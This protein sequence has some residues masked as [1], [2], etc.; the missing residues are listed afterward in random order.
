MMYHRWLVPCSTVLLFLACEAP[1]REPGGQAHQGALVRG[2]DCN[3]KPPG[4]SEIGGDPLGARLAREWSIRCDGVTPDRETVPALDA[5]QSVARIE[6]EAALP[7]VTLTVDENLG[8]LAHLAA[9]GWRGASADSFETG[10]EFWTTFSDSISGLLGATDLD[11]W[12]AEFVLGGGA[13]Q[14]D[15]L[16][17]KR[18]FDGIPVMGNYVHIT[19]L[20]AEKGVPATVSAVDTRFTPDVPSKRVPAVVTRPAAEAAQ[21]IALYGQHLG[22]PE[23]V[24]WTKDQESRLTWR[25]VFQIQHDDPDVPSELDPRIQF[26]AFLD[27]VT[28]E[29]VAIEQLTAFTTYNGQAKARATNPH[30]PFPDATA[31]AVGKRYKALPNAAIADFYTTR[32]LTVDNARTCKAPGTCTSPCGW[33]NCTDGKVECC[34]ADSCASPNGATRQTTAPNPGVEDTNITY[35]FGV[36]RTAYDGSFSREDNDSSAYVDNDRACGHDATCGATSVAA[37][38]TDSCMNFQ[39]SKFEYPLSLTSPTITWVSTDGTGKKWP[40]RRMEVFSLL[41]IASKHL[42]DD[43]GLASYPGLGFTYYPSSARGNGCVAGW[44]MFSASGDANT[45]TAAINVQAQAGHENPDNCTWW[46]ETDFRFTVF[47]E[48]SHSIH[49]KMIDTLGGGRPSGCYN[50]WIGEGWANFAAGS[51]SAGEDFGNNKRRIGAN[52]KFPKDDEDPNI[53]PE[54]GESELMTAFTSIFLDYYLYYGYAATQTIGYGLPTYIGQNPMVGNCTIAGDYT[55]CP[56]GSLYRKLISVAGSRW[57]TGSKQ[58][59]EVAKAFHNH[60]MDAYINANE[61]NFANCDG[62]WWTDNQTYQAYPYPDEVTDHNEHGL[63]MPV[64]KAPYRTTNDVVFPEINRGPDEYEARDLWF[65][66]AD[67]QDK[68]SLLVRAGESFKV[69]TTGLVNG[70]DT[71]LEILDFA[72]NRVGYNDDC[73]PPDRSSCVSFTNS[74]GSPQFYRIVTRAY[75]SGTVG[76]SKTY[77]IR[78]TKLADDYSNTQYAP[79]PVSPDLEFRYGRL[80]TSGDQDHFY[81]YIPNDGAGSR[82]LF[83][84]FC[85]D[86][87]G[88]RLQIWTGTTM[89]TET[90]RIADCENNWVT[91]G[92]ESLGPGLYRIVVVSPSAGVTGNY[93]FRLFAAASWPDQAADAYNL[94]SFPGYP[95]SGI[96]G[97]PAMVK[98]FSEDV[99]WFK[100]SANAGDIV[101]LNATDGTWTAD[102]VLTLY[103]PQKMFCGDGDSTPPHTGCSGAQPG[104]TLPLLVDDNGGTLT[105]KDSSIVFVAPWSGTYYLKANNIGAGGYTLTYYKD[106]AIGWI[107]SYLVDRGS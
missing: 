57:Y 16:I 52:R 26:V 44:G 29:P 36:T 107:P 97:L 38:T 60:V 54:Y 101:H 5:P 63:L 34:S 64:E 18:L 7:N 86:H 11:D 50:Y 62:G 68:W 99:A 106:H 23:L 105:N 100:F 8:T 59:Y 47:H 25:G 78:V 73:V 14:A 42:H 72:A 96:K 83:Y 65:T 48:F 56:A 12:H 28:F 79:H 82:D 81:T 85:A 102:P 2:V 70:A 51:V 43:L 41:N 67:D 98:L 80:E 93:K 53:N 76:L 30:D 6:I 90:T 10:W 69:E 58:R 15:V 94:D 66:D 87:S 75:S 40:G 3:Q 89:L 4:L 71:T 17:L 37:E 103:G 46:N 27:A 31:G 39:V 24:Y 35:D 22:E 88:A 49:Q 13:G 33:N 84:S 45:H 104:E 1:E 32:V 91:N 61:P 95:T 9:V 19:V 21:A 20:R 74:S 92:T 55:S 77:R